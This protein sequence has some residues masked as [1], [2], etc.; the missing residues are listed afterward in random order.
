MALPLKPGNG[1]LFMKVG[2]HAREPLDAIFAR[3]AKESFL[4][5]KT[6]IVRLSKSLRTTRCCKHD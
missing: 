5:L 3:K 1:L 6:I 4:K 2:T